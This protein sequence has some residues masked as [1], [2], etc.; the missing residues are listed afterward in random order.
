MGSQSK[1]DRKLKAFFHLNILQYPYL[2]SSQSK[3]EVQMSKFGHSYKDSKI[4]FRR[5]KRETN[6]EINNDY[7]TN[8]SCSSNILESFGREKNLLTNFLGIHKRIGM[9]LKIK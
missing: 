2:L 9:S 3:V 5:S 4:I 7:D 8:L 6:S 1:K